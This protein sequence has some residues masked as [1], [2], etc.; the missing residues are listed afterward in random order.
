MKHTYG[1]FFVIVKLK[2]AAQ[3]VGPDQTWKKTIFLHEQGLSPNNFTRN[4]CINYNKSEFATKQHKMY[5]QN[6]TATQL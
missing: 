6:G 5:E 3:A 2:P 4:S 1:F